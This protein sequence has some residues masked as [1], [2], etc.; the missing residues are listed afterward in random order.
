MLRFVGGGDGGEVLHKFGIDVES[1]TVYE[2]TVGK[3]GINN[4]GYGRCGG[5]GGASEIKGVAK[6]NGGSGGCPKTQKSRFEYHSNGDGGSSS[7]S[8]NAVGTFLRPGDGAHGGRIK[9]NGSVQVFGGGGGGGY[10]SNIYIDSHLLGREERGEVEMAPCAK[11]IHLAAWEKNMLVAAAGGLL[12]K[13][14]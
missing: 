10:C 11:K 3:G 7:T 8:N 5:N 14:L 9:I 1:N 12:F 6:A 13:C 4:I 2:V